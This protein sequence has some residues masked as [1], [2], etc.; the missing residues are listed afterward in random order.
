MT[1]LLTT[2]RRQLVDRMADLGP[3]FAARAERYDREASFPSE[4]FDDLG[5]AGFLSLCVPEAHGGL[6]ADFVTY[7]L[8]SEELGRHCGSTALTFNMH[9]ATMLLTGSIADDLDMSDPNRTIHEE[10]R[11]ALYEAVVKE[12]HVHS[13]PFSEGHEA[14]A[15]A[16]V[17]TRAT[18]VEGG[19]LV[20]GRKIFASL[21]ESAHHHNITCMVEGEQAI[22]FLGVPA[23]AAGITI[24]GEWDPL[25]MRG[26]V[27]KN[28]VF[29]DVFV[30]ADQEYL[31]A[32]CFDQAAARWPYFFM[33]LTFTYLGL[34]RAVLDFTRDYLRGG[35]GPDE[36]RNHFQK[37]HGWAQMRLAHEHS[38]ALVYRVLGEVGV[39]PTPTQIHRAWAAVVSVMETAPEVASL[40][41]RVCGGRSLLRPLIL[42]RLYR[43]ARCGATML[44]WSVEV[45]LDRLGRADLFDDEEVP[46]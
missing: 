29:D 21:S 16:G 46:A 36:R 14:G 26:T 31:P 42:E 37:Q 4:N 10:R 28:L 19:W 12:G 34:Q 15:A 41:V 11:A 9:T 35:N 24:E 40:A 7:A 17:T 5:E 25:G 3:T 32:G 45:C 22:R 30:P 43:D 8:V 1:D 27:S 6:G 33:T 2:A 44:P 38:Q 23:D 13:Q 20:S 39:D 18:G